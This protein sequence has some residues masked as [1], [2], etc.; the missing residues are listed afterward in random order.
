MRSGHR[1]VRACLGQF[2]FSDSRPSPGLFSHSTPG[3][4]RLPPCAAGCSQASSNSRPSVVMVSTALTIIPLSSALITALLVIVRRPPA[5]RAEMRDCAGMLVGDFPANSAAHRTRELHVDH[6]LPP[7]QASSHP[8]KNRHDHYTSWYR[9]RLL[10][11]AEVERLWCSCTADFSRSWLP[12][13]VMVR[14]RVAACRAGCRPC[15]VAVIRRDHHG[16]TGTM[17]SVQRSGSSSSNSFMASPLR[18]VSSFPSPFRSACRLP[19]STQ[20]VL[21]SR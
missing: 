5:L 13:A 10:A 12:L 8:L 9:S 20:P 3:T 2:P 19:I 4:L 11:L 18:I 15:S 14:E 21:S 17:S 1:S 6:A 16:S 7:R